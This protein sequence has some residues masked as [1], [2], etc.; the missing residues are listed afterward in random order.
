MPVQSL[1][2]REERLQVH[3]SHHWHPDKQT[4]LRGDNESPELVHFTFVLEKYQI[5]PE[6]KYGE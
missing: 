1:R 2:R 4:P 6:P 5:V 3:N